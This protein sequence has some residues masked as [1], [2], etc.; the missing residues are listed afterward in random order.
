MD[1]VLGLLL[2]AALAGLTYVFLLYKRHKEKFKNIEDTQEHLEKLKAEFNELDDKFRA[3]KEV[4]LKLQSEIDVLEGK[5]YLLDV[6]LYDRSFLFDNNEAYEYKLEQIRS[7]QKEMVR[8]KSAWWWKPDWRVNGSLREG[9]KMTERIRRLLMLA[10]NGICDEA[11]AKVRWNNLSLFEQR[12]RKSFEKI[13][14]MASVNEV[15]I[16]EPYCELKLSE[17]RLAHEFQ[18]YKQH[19]KEEEREI[20]ERMRDE[21]K[22]LEEAK[23]AEKEAEAEELRYEKALAKARAQLEGAHGEK[24]TEAQERIKEL[25]AALKEAEE[26]KQRAISLAQ[27]TRRGHVYIIS[28]QGSFGEGV[29]KIG[30]TRRLDPLDRVRELGDASVPFQFDIHAIIFTEDAPSLENVLHK[31]FDSM[32]LNLV[33]GRKEFFSVSTSDVKTVLAELN[34]E[35]EFID[36]AEAREYKETIAIRDRAKIEEQLAAEVKE[37]NSWLPDSIA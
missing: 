37:R 22:A 24:L 12:I 28:N 7:E 33:N 31:R 27:Q 13:N 34:L 14:E 2:V 30:M 3:G 20:R 36:D 23:R 15:S 17:L 32:R 6:G 11:I 9:N 26:K 8:S 4:F 5:S 29:L 10:F 35:H 25:E 18:E 16:V 19:K 1:I 21:T